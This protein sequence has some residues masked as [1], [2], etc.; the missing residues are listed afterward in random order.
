M[1]FPLSAK[2]GWLLFAKLRGDV[3]YACVRS[4]RFWKSMIWGR[5]RSRSSAG[6]LVKRPLIR[7]DSFAIFLGLVEVLVVLV[8]K[9]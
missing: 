5:M 8:G 9:Y 7:E 3:V 6:N 2:K 4:S 1:Y